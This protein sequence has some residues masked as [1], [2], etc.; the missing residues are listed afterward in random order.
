MQRFIK[1]ASLTADSCRCLILRMAWAPPQS[2]G[3][4]FKDL[5]HNEKVYWQRPEKT[6]L[7][8]ITFRLIK[9][10]HVWLNGNDQGDIIST[11]PSVRLSNGSNCWPANIKAKNRI[12]CF[13]QWLL[14]VFDTINQIPAPR[15]YKHQTAPH[16]L[17]QVAE[18]I[19]EDR[20]IHHPN[21]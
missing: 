11:P 13:E 15:C 8:I 1:Q 7:R 9:K 16:T 6:V 4:Q 2:L 3:G 17:P 14:T 21:N 10:G 19:P 5:G 18:C 12:S 20:N